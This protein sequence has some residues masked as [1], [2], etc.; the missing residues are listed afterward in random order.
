MIRVELVLQQRAGA[1][2][3]VLRLG[4]A[5]AQHLHQLRGAG[6]RV[7]Q[8][9]IDGAGPA[10]LRRRAARR[11]AEARRRFGQRLL[12]RQIEQL[13]RGLDRASRWPAAC[14]RSR[15]TRAAFSSPSS[16]TPY[17]PRPLGRIV[18]LRI[19]AVDDAR[20]RGAGRQQDDVVLGVEIAR[21]SCDFTT[22]WLMPYCSS[23]HIIQ[24]PG[25]LLAPSTDPTF[26]FGF[27]LKPS[28][29]GARSAAVTGSPEFRRGLLDDLLRARRRRNH[30]VPG[31]N[32]CRPIRTPWP[33]GRS[34]RCAFCS[35]VTILNVPYDSGPIR[36]AP[37]GRAGAGARQARRSSPV[38]AAPRT[39]SRSHRR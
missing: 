9:A 7:A 15:Q 18:A 8:R 26:V 11:R 31:A 21:K 2:E 12:D 10:P 34:A 4:D 37:F 33:R 16:P 24:P 29:A 30:E 1:V 17:G 27:S 28:T 19:E 25:M 13:A 5:I 23:I 3:Q 35:S 32:F 20:A 36:Y 38:R 39:A 22:S 14:R 6:E